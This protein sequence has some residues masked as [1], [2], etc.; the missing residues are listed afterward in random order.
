[1]SG[2]LLGPIL[3]NLYD[4]RTNVM[5]RIQPWQGFV[6][7][8]GRSPCKTPVGL[9]LHT[10]EGIRKAGEIVVVDARVNEGGWE[11]NL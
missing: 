1:M 5:L 8:E 3:E 7:V 11:A 4:C 2:P 10:K 6:R 9:K